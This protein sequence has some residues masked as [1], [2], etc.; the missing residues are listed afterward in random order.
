MK[1]VSVSLWELTRKEAAELPDGKSI[2]V[3]D[4]FLRTYRIERSGKG[5]IARSRY[6][7][8]YLKYFVFD[9]DGCDE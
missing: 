9:L 8:S 1:E 7:V 2:L 5:C 4:T 3:Y 6:A